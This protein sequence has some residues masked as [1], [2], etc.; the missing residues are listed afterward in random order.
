ML[1]V[2][3]VAAAGA[4]RR[5]RERRY[6]SFWRH[7]LMA[8]KMATL[9]ACHHS[10]QKKP[11][12]THAA[13]QADLTHGEVT[14]AP[15][16]TYA[17]PAPV[18]GFVAPSPAVTFAAPAPVIDYVAPAHSVTFAAPAPVFVSV[19]PAP[20]FQSTSHQH[21]LCLLLRP[22][23]IYVL[24]TPQLPFILAS[25][26]TPSLWVLRHRSLVHLLSVKCLLRPCF[27]KFIM[28]RLLEMEFLRTWWISLLFRNR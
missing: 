25:T 22:A 16:V 19:A 27:I 21:L 15:A 1:S 4:A 7:E 23:N 8:V 11:A 6:R 18:F 9:T 26:L 10:A 12:V 24:T 14:S 5:R 20:V 13:T 3:R 28:Y 2:A 17:A